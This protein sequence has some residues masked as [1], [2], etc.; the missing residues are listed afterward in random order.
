MT[1]TRV[2]TTANPNLEMG[3]VV[4]CD[5]PIAVGALIATQ[6]VPPLP[7]QQLFL[8]ELSQA[9]NLGHTNGILPMVSAARDKGIREVFVPMV[10]APRQRWW[11]GC[12]CTRWRRWR[13]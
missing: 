10:D 4:P 7:D 3:R 9:D 8:G 5:L 6:Q 12:G 1:S 2:K 11:K 13:S